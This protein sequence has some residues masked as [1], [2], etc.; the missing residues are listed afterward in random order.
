MPNKPFQFGLGSLLWLTAAVA[1]GA[2]LWPLTLVLLAILG[3]GIVGGF[4]A[5]LPLYAGD[6]VDQ[7]RARK[8]L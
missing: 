5:W 3:A 4:I 6:V 1:V 2:A 7:M 8:H